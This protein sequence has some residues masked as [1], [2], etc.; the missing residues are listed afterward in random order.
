M[1][2]WRALPVAE[3]S[4]VRIPG[5]AAATSAHSSGLSSMKIKELG[6]SCHSAASCATLVDFGCQETFHPV[7]SFRSRTISGR[8]KARRISR[9][10]FL[11]V[12][13]SRI[14]RRESSLSLRCS[15]SLGGQKPIPSD[16]ASPTTPSQ[17]VLSASTSTA[18]NGG[19]KCRRAARI[20]AAPSAAKYSI[21]YGMRPCRSLSASWILSTGYHFRT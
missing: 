1:S 17:S 15:A 20:K 5:K 18:L 2:R 10:S 4:K 13:A 14:P 19:W 8:S 21:V 16:P 6:S 11:L 3:S 12:S 7:K 9:V